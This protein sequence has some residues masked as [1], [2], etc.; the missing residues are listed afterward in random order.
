MRAKAIEG[1][2]AQSLGIQFHAPV[3]RERESAETTKGKVQTEQQSAEILQRIE[4]REIGGVLEP[5]VSDVE[6]AL[7]P[8]GRGWCWSGGGRTC[9]AVIR[10]RVSALG[11]ISCNS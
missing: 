11:N 8:G 5:E 1:A 9:E 7:H 4:V 10:S 2:Y 3:G 6:E